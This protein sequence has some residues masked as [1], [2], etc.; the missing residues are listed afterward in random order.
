MLPQVII[1]SVI[2]LD[3]KIE[4]FRAEVI[5]HYYELSAQL[6][7]DTW[8]I[9]ADTLLEAERTPGTQV[10]QK[11]KEG[12]PLEAVAESGGV[13]IAVPDSRGRMRNWYT[14]VEGIGARGAV[15]LVSA[16]SPSPHIEYLQKR[17]IPFIKAG[18][19]HVDYRA[20]LLELNARFGSKRIRTDSGGVLSSIL[21]EE[22][23]ATELSLLIAP[24]LIGNEGRDLFRTLGLK[25][26]LH[27]D[28]L[29]CQR[30]GENSIWLR[31]KV[32]Y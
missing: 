18:A 2:S 13:L 12:E 22:R 8:L 26:A 24:D 23:L 9:G 6:K 30:V 32:Q 29:D 7:C 3:G 11:D 28:L 17:N 31:Y 5:G 19:D 21:L 25:D 15:A 4:G 27:L 14:H 1:H 10:H 20:A 16:T